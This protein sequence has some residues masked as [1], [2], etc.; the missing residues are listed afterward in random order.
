MAI[1]VLFQSN[2]TYIIH[3]TLCDRMPKRELHVVTFS[4]ILGLALELA[5]W[6]LSPS[7]AP[8]LFIQQRFCFSLVL[9]WFP[10]MDK[11][12]LCHYL[13]FTCTQSR[14]SFTYRLWPWGP[15]RWI[16]KLSSIKQWQLN[17]L[18]SFLFF[19]IFAVVTNNFRIKF[20][21][22]LH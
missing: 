9:V 21:D 16:W 10:W 12:K 2:N 20:S 15:L 5:V 13:G 22:R 19:F 14:H 8:V 11:Q 4:W 6:S 3:C 18:F 1:S 17:K 7:T